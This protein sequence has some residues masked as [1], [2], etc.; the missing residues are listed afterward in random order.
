VF[1]PREFIA[2]HFAHAKSREGP[3]GAESAAASA[4]FALMVE[5]GFT[6]FNKVQ[7]A[8]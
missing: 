5:S 1:C 2:P 6:H 8:A 4:S 3:G 7:D